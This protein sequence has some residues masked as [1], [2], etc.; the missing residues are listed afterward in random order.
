MGVMRA[1]RSAKPQRGDP[2][3][4][5]ARLEVLKAIP[6]DPASRE[7]HHSRLFAKA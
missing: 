6:L 3:I 4:L 5:A 7:A 2:F 1:Q